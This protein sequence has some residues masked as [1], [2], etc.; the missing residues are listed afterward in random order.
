VRRGTFSIVALGVH[1]DYGM[2]VA[3]NASGARKGQSFWNFGTSMLAEGLPAKAISRPIELK[4]RLDEFHRV[5]LPG[6]AVAMAVRVLQTV[7]EPTSK[8]R[9]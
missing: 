2:P 7:K 6:D 5:P 9:H 3:L 1:S 4:F 8:S